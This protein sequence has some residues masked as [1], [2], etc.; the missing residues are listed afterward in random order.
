MGFD[1]R[2]ERL[3]YYLSGED[4]VLID[5][6]PELAS[7]RDVVYLFKAMMCPS[8]S[9]L[10]ELKP[11]HPSKARLK[12]RVVAKESTG[13]LFEVSGFDQTALKC[14]AFVVSGE[15]GKAPGSSGA[16]N[17]GSGAASNTGSSTAS[18]AGGDSA[19]SGE[20]TAAGAV[21]GAVSGSLDTDGDV[22]SGSAGAG[23][24]AGA[25]KKKGWGSGF[26][27]ALGFGVEKPRAPPSGADPSVLCGTRIATEDD[28]LHVRYL[29]GNK[30]GS[31]SFGQ[32]LGNGQCGRNRR[33]GQLVLASVQ[34]ALA[35]SFVVSWSLQ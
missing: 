33:R 12:W 11:W 19:G 25:S 31:S 34:S 15:K 6:W 21:G 18:T 4:P 1:R 26:L 32:Q 16:G 14:N 29:P 17:T 9:S 5:L 20:G 10:P 3:P 35:H 8:S 2:P 22:S 27:S 7:F 13:P 28:V 30:V 23:A 24:A